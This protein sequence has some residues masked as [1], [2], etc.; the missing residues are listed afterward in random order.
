MDTWYFHLL[1]MCAASALIPFQ[2]PEEAEVIFHATK[3]DRY[4]R[5]V[6]A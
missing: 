2:I 4:C 5:E 1:D 3:A 6:I